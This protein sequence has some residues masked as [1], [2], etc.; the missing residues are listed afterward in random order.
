MPSEKGAG[1][2]AVIN[3]ARV[4]YAKGTTKKR[5]GEKLLAY[6]WENGHLSPFEQV[7]LKFYVKAPIFVLRQ[8]MRHRTFSF[9]EQ[10]HRYSEASEEYYAP[11]WFST[12]DTKNKQGSEGFVSDEVQDKAEN[13]YV[14]A[15]ESAI[16][17]YHKLLQLGVSREQARCILPV[18][19]FTSMVCSVNMRNLFNFLKQRLHPHAQYEMRC[20]AR[21]L[22]EQAEVIAPVSFSLFLGGLE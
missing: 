22:V 5:S 11:L 3:A 9:N 4:S 13:E 12:Q 21:A 7:Q 15:M 17:R 8:W 10:S 20:Y 18:G 6:L 19:I 16:T 14:F 1:D 2:K